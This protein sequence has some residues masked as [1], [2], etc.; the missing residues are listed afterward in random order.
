MFKIFD[1]CLKTVLA[2]MGLTMIVVGFMQVFWRYVLHHSLTWS[3]ELLRYLFVWIVLV[4]APTGIPTGSHVS[5][6][7]IQKKIPN[8]Y[9]GYYQIFL[10]VLILAGFMFMAIWGMPYALSNFDHVSP[11]MQIPFG[12]VILAVPVGGIVGIAYTVYAITQQVKKNR[13][14]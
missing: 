6:D 7:L 11:A 9:H 13:E 2:L 4:G 1:K 14:V 3:E 10:Y 12:W 8:K 5:F